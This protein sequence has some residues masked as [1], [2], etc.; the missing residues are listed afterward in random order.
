MIA[1]ATEEVLVR[2]GHEV[3]GIARTVAA[4]VALGRTHKPDLAIIDVRLA[5][6]EIGTEIPIQLSGSDRC[7]ILYTTGNVARLMLADVAGDACLAKPYRAVDLLRSLELVAEIVAT[8]TA[9]SP[10]PQGFRVLSR[11]VTPSRE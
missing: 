2:S 8:G 6:G 1:K 3:C 10:F 11:I 7:G 5:E 9:T 4:A